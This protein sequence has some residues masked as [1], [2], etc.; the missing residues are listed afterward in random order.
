MKAEQRHAGDI[1]KRRLMQRKTGWFILLMLVPSIYGM[2][3]YIWINANSLLL[4]FSNLEPVT[5]GFTLKWFRMLFDEMSRTDTQIFQAMLNTFKCFGI[6]C[7]KLV[8]SYVIAYFLYKQILL[9]KA[10][11]FVFFLPSIVAPVINVF[12]FSEIIAPLGPIDMI[13]GMKESYPSLIANPD[14]VMGTIL[15][16]DLLAGFGTNFL[17]ILGAMNRIP[18][19]YLEAA[20]IDGCKPWREFWML[21]TPLV[22][23]NFSTLVILQLTSIFT[24]SG[25]ILYFTGGNGDPYTLSFWIFDQVRGD[26]YNYPSAVGIFFTL[27]GIPIVFFIRW[28][29]NKINPEVS[30]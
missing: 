11:R 4:A 16:Y 10:F 18:P 9:H 26:I 30:Y 20:A 7:L 2:F 23:E 22:W 21:V 24:A 8:L 12:I 17:I 3:R 6:G 28:A 27:I 25:P 15:L 13:L 19:E 5:S 29:V 14:T 1:L